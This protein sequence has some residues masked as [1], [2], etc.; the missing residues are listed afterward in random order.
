M[1]RQPG[2]MCTRD[3]GWQA[4]PQR[5]ERLR[6]A[7]AVAHHHAVGLHGTCTSLK[8]MNTPAYSNVHVWC[9]QGHSI[10]FPKRQS[11]ACVSVILPT[12]WHVCQSFYQLIGMCV[13][14]FT[15]SLACVSVILPTHWHVCQSFY[16]LRQLCCSA[17]APATL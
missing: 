15:N 4:V 13:S 12:H 17:S 7:H 9:E 14:H 3:N 8:F 10:T 16:Q 6:V 11:L 2:T 5:F 1:V